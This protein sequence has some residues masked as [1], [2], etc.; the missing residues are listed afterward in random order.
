MLRVHCHHLLSILKCVQ[1][2]DF[3]PTTAFK[4]VDQIRDKVQDGELKTGEDIRNAMKQLIIDILSNKGNELN[5]SEEKPSVL[6]V[7]GVN[8]G[9]K[10][11]TI[12]KLAYKFS[13]EGASVMLAAGDTF[14]AAAGEQLDQW[15]KRS[16]AEIVL[17]ENENTRPDTVLYK[18]VGSAIEKGID[19]VLC[20]T[21]GRLHTNWGLMEELA[22][23]KKSIGKC[24]D[25][26]PHETLLV[27]DGTTGMNMLNQAKEFNESVQLTGIILTK[28]DGS[29]RGGAVVSVVDEL[30]LPI[31]MVGVGESVEDLQPFDPESFVDAL[32]PTHESS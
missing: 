16:S 21:S 15:A 30:G 3:G 26:A 19:L 17:A 20:D 29:S 31:K 1:M 5:L 24:L 23:C 11:T 25:G 27:L 18:A 13:N 28:L 14:R 2:A 10:T 7:V 9:G 4:I 8:G 22:K 12:G 6:L 32:F